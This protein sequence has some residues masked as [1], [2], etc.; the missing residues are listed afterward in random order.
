MIKTTLLSQAGSKINCTCKFSV[1]KFL[2]VN[3]K[4]RFYLPTWGVCS[5]YK[6]CVHS[7]DYETK[8]ICEF[9]AAHQP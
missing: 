8:K 1:P 9:T 6:A 3:Q 2:H 7:S 5:V 4:F